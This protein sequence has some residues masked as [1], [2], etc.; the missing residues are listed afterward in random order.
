MDTGVG[1]FSRGVEA[2]DG[3]VS[4]EVGFNSAHHIVSSRADWRHIGGEIEPV[5]ETGGVDTR[6]TFL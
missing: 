6:E 4:P 3:S 5:A 2:G 1:G